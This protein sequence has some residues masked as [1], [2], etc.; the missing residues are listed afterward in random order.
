MPNMLPEHKHTFVQKYSISVSYFCM[1]NTAHSVLYFQWIVVVQ[2][3]SILSV[4]EVWHAFCFC[5]CICI[6]SSAVAYFERLW[7]LT[8][9]LSSAGPSHFLPWSP[10]M[11]GCLM[12]KIAPK[13]IT[14][15]ITHGSMLNNTLWLYACIQPGC[16][17]M[18]VFVFLFVFAN[19]NNSDY[20]N[21]S[22]NYTVWHVLNASFRMSDMPRVCMQS[23]HFLQTFLMGVL[24]NILY[25]YSNIRICIWTSVFVS[26]CSLK[27]GGCLLWALVMSDTVLVR[28]PNISCL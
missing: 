20:S 24:V 12:A 25:L 14:V 26:E 21:Y 28:T 8:C 15:K 17:F 22:E 7:C 27:S 9:F 19:N 2:Q 1:L 23:K 4:C 3:W 5:I 6:C 16:I 13:V 18:N 10:I 11:G